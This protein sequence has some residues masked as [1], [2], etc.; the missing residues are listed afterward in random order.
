VAKAFR[1]RTPEESRQSARYLPHFF[2]MASSG[3]AGPGL[4]AGLVG[5]FVGDL[6]CRRLAVQLVGDF[7]G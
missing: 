2:C 7:R 4:V 6:E 5:G 3:K 1:W